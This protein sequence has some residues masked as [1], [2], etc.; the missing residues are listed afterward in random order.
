[1][2]MK[3][4]IVWIDWAKAIGI[5]IVVFCHTPQNDN[6]VKSFFI[7]ISDA[8]IFYIGRIFA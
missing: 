7:C 4:R 1:M 3:G 8:T 6:F 5:M 2:E